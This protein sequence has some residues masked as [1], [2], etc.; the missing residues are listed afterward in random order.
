[1]QKKYNIVNSFIKEINKKNQ[2]ILAIILY[3]SAINSSNSSH[4]I[5][6]QIIINNSKNFLTENPFYKL[7]AMVNIKFPNIHITIITL[8]E[9]YGAFCSPF[10]R[11]LMY[12]PGYK[13]IYNPTSFNLKRLIGKNRNQELLNQFLAKINNDDKIRWIIAISEI[14]KTLNKSR[15]LLLK[16]HINKIRKN[17]YD[18]ANLIKDTFDNNFF[19]AVGRS[20]NPSMQLNI[21][22]KEAGILSVAKILKISKKQIMKNIDTKKL[23]LQTNPKNLK[24][25]SLI[26]FCNKNKNLVET[27]CYYV[28]EFIKNNFKQDENRNKKINLKNAD[29]G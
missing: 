11:T 20:F 21:D 22:I 25:N 12:S 10:D 27:S 2:N 29:K 9:L 26:D 14:A 16:A 15:R 4:D 6:M 24:Y 5:D 28:E 7:L 3:G 19:R 17:I 8:K 18:A 13:I 23:I 1:M